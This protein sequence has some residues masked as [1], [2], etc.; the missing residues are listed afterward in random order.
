MSVDILNVDM[1]KPFFNPQ[2]HE[3]GNPSI[4]S[5]NEYQVEEK[6]DISPEEQM[7]YDTIFQ[8]LNPINGR[9]TGEQ[10]RPV[11]LNSQLP[12]TILARVCYYNCDSV[13][14]I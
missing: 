5:S 13:L 7:K 8:S 3:M 2:L 10:C 12:N 1:D 6:W 11:L 14:L 4:S 9:L